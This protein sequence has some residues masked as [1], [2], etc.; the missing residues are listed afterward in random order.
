MAESM[1]LTF[2]FRESTT[3]HF[4]NSATGLY[5]TTEKNFSL[6]GHPSSFCCSQR[7]VPLALYPNDEEL[8]WSLNTIE[9]MWRQNTKL[10]WINFYNQTFG[11]ADLHTERYVK[12][13][14]D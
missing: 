2:A 10:K 5:N 1:N 7:P 13:V 14:L 4:S 3:Q 12:Q 6:D 9:P 8:L 11:W